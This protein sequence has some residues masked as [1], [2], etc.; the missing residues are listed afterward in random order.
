MNSE[1]KSKCAVRACAETA[2]SIGNLCDR[3]RVPGTV[4]V[5][6]SSNRTYVITN[7]YAEHEGT[8][9]IV[10]LNDFALGHLFGG[11]E[12]FRAELMRQGFTAIHLLV[13]PEEFADAKEKVRAA[14]GRW[15]GPWSEQYPWET[16]RPAQ[17]EVN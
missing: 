3:H 10:V 17:Y 5:F 11:E 2:A 14:P 16:V 1:T 4:V 15:S 6:E 8:H 13:T 12:G 7:W 9:G